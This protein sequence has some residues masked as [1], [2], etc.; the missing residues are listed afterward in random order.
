VVEVAPAY[1]HGEVTTLAAATVVYD[2]VTLM[3][4]SGSHQAP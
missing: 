3:A 4:T 1:D 2:L